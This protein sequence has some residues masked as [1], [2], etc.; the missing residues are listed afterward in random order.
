MWCLP[1]PVDPLRSFLVC[2]GE[3]VVQP[4][5][6]HHPSPV[7][8]ALNSEQERF[9]VQDPDWVEYIMPPSEDVKMGIDMRWGGTMEFH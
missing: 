9:L 6:V 4:P 5:E 3:Y 8:E 1:P 2:C 7:L